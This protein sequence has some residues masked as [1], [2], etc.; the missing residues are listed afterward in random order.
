MEPHGSVGDPPETFADT[1]IE[2]LKEGWESIY[3][4]DTWRESPSLG[5]V[6][7]AHFSTPLK[8]ARHYLGWTEGEVELRILAHFSGRGS[9]LI[10]IAME[11]GIDVQIT[12][13]WRRAPRSFEGYLKKKYKNTPRLC[14]ACMG[15]DLR[16]VRIGSR[17]RSSFYRQF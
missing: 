15:S 12:R 13:I 10:R 2:D 11:Q 17:W 14:P 9:R 5:S 16:E 4:P 8:H 6:Y 3:S 1:L 7:L